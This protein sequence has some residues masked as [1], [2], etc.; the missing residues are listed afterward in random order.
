MTEW[1]I[2][3]TTNNMFEITVTKSGTSIIKTGCYADFPSSV[4]LDGAK[5]TIE[6]QLDKI[7]AEG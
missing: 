1:S 2:K 3:A 5:K 4:H 6:N 7:I